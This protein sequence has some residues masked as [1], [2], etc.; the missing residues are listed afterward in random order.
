VIESLCD[1]VTEK[2]RRPS[3]PQD[4]GRSSFAS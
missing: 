1:Q 3:T 2:D 4:K